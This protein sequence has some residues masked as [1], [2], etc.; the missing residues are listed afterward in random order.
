MNKPYIAIIGIYNEN[1][2]E[3][4]TLKETLVQ[5]KDEKEAHKVAFYKCNVRENQ[6]VLKVLEY[7]TRKVLFDHLK[8]FMA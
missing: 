6:T 3:Q 5:A 4:I 2:T 1:T 7:N 8:G